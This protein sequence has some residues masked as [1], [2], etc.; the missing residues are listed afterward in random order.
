M[1]ASEYTSTS[2]PFVFAN[3]DAT[4]YGM[5]GDFVNGWDVDVLQDAIDTCT[6]AS[7]QVEK[8]AA[9]TLFTRDEA[10]ACKI[11]VT[12]AEKVDGTLTK[13]P[14]CNDISY[15]PDRAPP[16]SSSCTDTTTF[17]PAPGIFTDLTPRGWHYLGCGTDSVSDRAFKSAYTASNNM[18]VET[19]FDFCNKA[20][21]SYAGLEYSQECFCGNALDPRYAPKDGVMGK[22]D[23]KC[24]GDDGEMC[25]GSGTMSVYGKCA[26]GSTCTN[27]GAGGGAKV[28]RARRHAKELSV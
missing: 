10:A 21:W 28:K 22:C 16:P 25:G 8:C 6:D 11:P 13:L 2:H 7:G 18:T 3:G 14:G 27:V 19:C 4:G 9:V 12:V 17:G 24:K 26:T 20:G 5:H 1:F 23:M 15:G